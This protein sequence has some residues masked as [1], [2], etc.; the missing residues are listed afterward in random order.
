MIVAIR[1]RI[2]LKIIATITTEVMAKV[3]KIVADS[4]LLK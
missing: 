3:T 2:T 4:N 1:T